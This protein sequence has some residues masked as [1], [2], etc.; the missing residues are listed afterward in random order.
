MNGNV[1]SPYRGGE[2]YST[3]E[4]LTSKDSLGLANIL[5]SLILPCRF[6]AYDLWKLKNDEKKCSQNKSDQERII[7]SGIFLLI[8]FDLKGQG[9]I[10]Y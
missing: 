1:K 6:F 10:F 2:V 9:R 7:D 4:H 5:A 8:P 3:R